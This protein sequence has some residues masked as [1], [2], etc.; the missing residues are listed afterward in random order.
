MP[1]ERK[2]SVAPEGSRSSTVIWRVSTSSVFTAPIALP[3]RERGP[4]APMTTLARSREPSASSTTP[5][6]PSF[7]TKD[8]RRMPAPA[9][10]ALEHLPGKMRVHVG[11]VVLDERGHRIDALP[12][13][14]R[15]YIQHLRHEFCAL[16]GNAGF[17]LAIERDHLAAGAR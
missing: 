9:A 15:R 16:H 14:T 11:R 10:R 3:A 7:V 4:S 8:E 6:G 17:A 13:G 5:V 1:A 12:N 2:I